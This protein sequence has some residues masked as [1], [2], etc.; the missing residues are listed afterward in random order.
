MADEAQ[1]K[2]TMAWVAMPP[3]TGTAV[4]AVYRT[5]WYNAAVASK[6]R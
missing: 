2:A 3:N 1:D 4:V 5:K 6:R